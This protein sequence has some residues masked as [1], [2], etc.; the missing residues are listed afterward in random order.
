MRILLIAV[1]VTATNISLSMAQSV[2][3]EIQVGNQISWTHD[4]KA[5]N[6]TTR[7]VD[8][9]ILYHGVTIDAMS[10]QIEFS[11][12]AALLDPA[13]NRFKYMAIDVPA[14]AWKM[15]CFAMTAYYLMPDQS[16]LESQKSTSL[17]AFIGGL[18]SPVKDVRI[19]D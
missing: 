7:I 6:G 2:P 1:L 4:N 13:D 14:L 19:T 16:K 10:S 12:P 15:N 11:D 8:G 5:E 17:C 18:P 9:F 3:P